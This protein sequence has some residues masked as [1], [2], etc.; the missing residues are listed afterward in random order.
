MRNLVAATAVERRVVFYLFIAF[1]V[2]LAQVMPADVFAGGL[3]TG[4]NTVPVL[5]QQGGYEATSG[6]D[7][8]SSVRTGGASG[9][10]LGTYYSYFIEVP[11]ATNNLTVQI[12][13]ADVGAGGNAE[14]TLQHDRTRSTFSTSATYTLLNPSGTSV[15]AA[16]CAQANYCSGCTGAA[17]GNVLCNTSTVT[18]NAWV[19]MYNISSGVTA[20]HWELRVQMSSNN[21]NTDING[22]G[23]RATDTSTGHELNIYAPSFLGMGVHP[24]STNKAGQTYTFYPFVTSGCYLTSNNF[25][26]DYGNGTA[27]NTQSVSVVSRTGS[28][29]YSPSLSPDDTWTGTQMNNWTSV[30]SAVDY[31]IWSETAIIAQYN[32]NNGQNGNYAVLWNGK[33]TQV[34]AIPTA[35]PQTNSFRLYLPNTAG[36]APAKPVVGQQLT[37]VSGPHN[38]PNVG[39]T[40]KYRVEIFVYN[41][42]AFPI[43]FSNSNLVTAY[44]PGTVTNGTVTYAGAY[45]VGQGSATLPASGGSGLVSWNPGAVAAGATVAMTYDI[46]VHAA[47]TGTIVATGTTATNGTQAT[48]VDETGNTTQ[49]RATY[50]YGP[51]CELSVSS[52]V[53]TLATVSSIDAYAVG[54][55]VIVEWETSSEINTIG[56]YLLRFNDKTG[57]FE[58]VNDNMLPAMIRHNHGGIYRLQDSTAS[59]GKPSTY[60]IQEIEIKGKARKYGPFVVTPVASKAAPAAALIS[61]ES[62]AM[63]LPKGPAN[64]SPNLI[65]APRSNAAGQQIRIAIQEDGIYSIDASTISSLMGIPVATAQKLIQTKMLGLSNRGNAV[66][67]M[68]DNKNSRILFYGQGI[69]SVYTQKNIYWLKL[70]KG[71][72]MG[73][74][75]AGTSAAAGDIYFVTKQH[76]EENNFSATALATGPSDDYWFWDYIASGDPGTESRTFKLQVGNPSVASGKASLAVNLQGVADDSFSNDHHAIF[77]LNGTQIGTED[78]WTGADKHKATISFDQG[79]LKEGNNTLEIKGVFDPGTSYSLFYINSFDLTYY[80]L[81]KAEGDKL[82]CRSDQNPVVTITGFTDPNIKLFDITNPLAPKA[83]TATVQNNS[84]SFKP[85]AADALF[86]AVSE[87]AIKPVTEVSAYTPSTLKTNNSGADYLIITSPELKNSAAALAQYRKLQLLVPMVVTVDDIMN[88]FNYGIYSPD[89]IRDFLGYAKKNWSKPPKYVVLAGNGSYDYKDYLGL[90]GNIV[91]PIM[92]VTPDGLFPSDNHYADLNGDHIAEMAI[93]RLSAS[94]APELSGIIAKIIAYENGAAGTWSNQALLVA[95]IPDDGGNFT[96]DSDSLV[97]LFPKKYSIT[98]VYL[99]NYADTTDANAALMADINSG[100]AFMNYF[101]HG[102]LDRLTQDGLLMNGD[103]ASMTNGNK[104]PLMTAMTCIIGNFAFPGITSLGETLV[105]KTNGGAAAVWSATGLSDDTLAVSL[106]K[107]FYQSLFDGGSPVLG[108]VI[109]RAFRGVSLKAG[110]MYMIDIYTLLGDPALRIKG[111]AVTKPV[112]SPNMRRGE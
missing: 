77:T 54:G 90:G 42:T 31:G 51:L 36:S 87:S 32:N 69:D 101:G 76:F 10:G 25:D 55:S 6:G 109:L 30:F 21:G 41:P 8:I 102:G 79:L 68:T 52:G 96:Q 81:Y 80:K 111:I 73:T 4:N 37:F 65:V 112:V 46:N 11:S 3:P 2:V 93:G 53:P 33:Y 24:N 78:S 62:H 26:F 58:R 98:K 35:Q 59:V 16:T 103:V 43:T 91:P 100:A 27:E 12:Y 34:S 49:A 56:Y 5:M 47:V 29:T 1:F 17:N 104:L 57:Q 99:P 45:S 60:V 92:V 86:V 40:S 19:T 61:R 48:Y 14:S 66:A 72:L 94:T 97:T 75:T 67:Y 28:S 83:V 88:T 106:D 13:D 23:I 82:F 20:G 108:D 39:E 70:E 15:A 84:V 110:D 64:I 107:A 9:T 105:L 22:F 89:A 38:P 71:T 50:T 18:N 85:I 63:P 7:F 74:E 95:D 44:I